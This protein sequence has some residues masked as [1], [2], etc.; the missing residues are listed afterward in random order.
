[1]FDVL[2]VVKH[3]SHILKITIRLHSLHEVDSTPRPD[4]GHLVYK[5]LIGIFALTWKH[6]LLNE[7]AIAKSFKLRDV[8]HQLIPP[9]ISESDNLVLHARRTH[10]LASIQYNYK[11]IKT[12]WL[13]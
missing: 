7:G 11:L 8:M 10:V 4:F 9:R 2:D 5:Y 1:M 3:H 12:E 6:V 13:C